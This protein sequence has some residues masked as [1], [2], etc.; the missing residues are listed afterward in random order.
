M[1]SYERE[2]HNSIT[3][4]EQKQRYRNLLEI[5]RDLRLLLLYRTEKKFRPLTPKPPKS[6]SGLRTHTVKYCLVY[7]QNTLL[8]SHTRLC[9]MSLTD[10]HNVCFISCVRLC[11]L[12]TATSDAR[13]AA[14]IDDEASPWRRR[15][16]WTL[17]ELFVSMHDRFQELSRGRL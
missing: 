3:T 14:R 8:L 2:Y 5:W 4:L 11:I 12:W 16:G 13:A 1:Q 9:F 15:T 17:R 7:H 10:L 6:R